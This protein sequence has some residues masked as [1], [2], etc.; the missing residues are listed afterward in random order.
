MRTGEVGRAS[1]GRDHQV[2]LEFGLSVRKV[3]H[4]F[5]VVVLVSMA[6]GSGL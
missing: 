2:I 6:L 3:N 4:D 5:T 1:G